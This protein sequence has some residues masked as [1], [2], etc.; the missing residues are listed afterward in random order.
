MLYLM[1]KYADESCI[2]LPIGVSPITE[3]DY[4]KQTEMSML[5]TL[6]WY[7]GDKCQIQAPLIMK[8][9][10]FFNYLKECVDG[11]TRLSVIPLKL[12]SKTGLSHA[13]MLIYDKINNTLERFE[14]HGHE[15]PDEFHPYLLDITLPK[16]FAKFVTGKEVI[17]IPPQAFCPVKGHQ[18]IEQIERETLGITLAEGKGLCSVWS[19]IYANLRLQYPDKTN[20]EIMD[21]ISSQVTS[22]KKLYQYAENIIIAMWSL[23]EKIRVAKTEEDIQTA[24]LESVKILKI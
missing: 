6:T 21:F 20:I 10:D 8:T 18:V 15:S 17:Y 11:S 3:E 1:G 24:V 7:C 5:A 13:N 12:L 19:F 14:P 2:F 23:S 4:K 16:M 22:D 9:Q